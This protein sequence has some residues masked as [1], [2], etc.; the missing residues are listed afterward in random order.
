MKHVS[1]CNAIGAEYRGEF[2]KRHD[3]GLRIEILGIKG[4]M[5]WSQA[6]VGAQDK[7]ARIMSPFDRNLT[8]KVGHFRIHDGKH[9]RR[10]GLKIDAKR[11]CNMAGHCLGCSSGVENEAAAEKFFWIEIAQ[12]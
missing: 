2:A 7:F 6:S 9:A 5:Q 1:N 11:F 12:K 10:C 8:D 3:D 4:R